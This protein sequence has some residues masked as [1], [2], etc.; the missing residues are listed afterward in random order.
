MV[1]LKDPEQP[2]TMPTRQQP[3]RREQRWNS[4]RHKYKWRLITPQPITNAII[5]PIRNRTNLREWERTRLWRTMRN[6]IIERWK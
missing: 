4:D 1:E 5:I 6:S 3:Y 2:S